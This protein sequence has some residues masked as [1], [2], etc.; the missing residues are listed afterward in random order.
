MIGPFNDLSMSIETITF[1]YQLPQ[2]MYATRLFPGFL[3]F[4]NFPRLCKK[5]F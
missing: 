5:Y 3:N 1:I 4:T 2:D